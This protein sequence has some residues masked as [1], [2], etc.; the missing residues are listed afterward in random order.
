MRQIGGIADG[1]KR[2]SS[3]TCMHI[4]HIAFCCLAVFL[5]GYSCPIFSERM[6]RCSNDIISNATNH[7]V[8]GRLPLKLTKKRERNE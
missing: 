4:T 7:I 8:H 3:F 5:F 1:L 6:Q 2:A